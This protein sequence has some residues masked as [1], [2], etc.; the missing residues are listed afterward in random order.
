MKR[1]TDYSKFVWSLLDAPR[2]EYFNLA[3][4]P[5][6]DIAAKVANFEPPYEYLKNVRAGFDSAIR[7]MLDRCL[8]GDRLAC[9]ARCLCFPAKELVQTFADIEHGRSLAGILHGA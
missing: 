8:E 5:L 9:R 1:K 4:D 6:V 7:F 2:L 3:R